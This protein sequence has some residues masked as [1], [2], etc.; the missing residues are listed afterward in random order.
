MGEQFSCRPIVDWHCDEAMPIK[1]S[2][3]A[4]HTG[5]EHSQVIRLPIELFLE[6]RNGLVVEFCCCSP[7]IGVIVVQDGMRASRSQSKR[8]GGGGAG[9]TVL[10]GGGAGRTGGAAAMA[11]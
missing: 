11:C 1:L 4:A 3:P 6:G 2:S 8:G 9:N 5:Q 10:G 7:C